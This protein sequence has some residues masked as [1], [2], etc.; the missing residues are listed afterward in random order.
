MSLIA[1]KHAPWSP[2][3]RSAKHSSLLP[4]APAIIQPGHSMTFR[5]LLAELTIAVA[6]AGA[7]PLRAQQAVPGQPQDREPTRQLEPAAQ[8]ASSDSNSLAFREIDLLRREGFSTARQAT[9]LLHLQDRRGQQPTSLKPGDFKLLVNGTERPARIQF[10]GDPSLSAPPLFLLLFPPNQPI[11]HAIGTHQAQLYFAGQPNEL[12]PWKLALFDSDG[13]L[14]PFTNGRSQLLAWLDLSEHKTQPFQYTSDLGIPL[15]LHCRGPWL[16]AA[17]QAI[18]A[19]QPAE[20]AKVIIAFNPIADGLYGENNRVLANDEPQCLVGI[21]QSIGAHI[22]IANSGGPDISIVGGDASTHGAIRGGSPAFYLRQ[23]FAASTYFAYRASTMRQTA[24]ETFGGFSNTLQDLASQI[25]HNLDDNY[26]LTFDLTAHD[27]DKGVPDVEV[28]LAD[29]HQRLAIVNLYP[30]ALAPAPCQKV[31]SKDLMTA[32]WKAAERP[33]SSPS[34]HIAQHVDYFPLREGLQPVL[35]MSALVQW[36]GA[37]PAPTR[38][39]VAEYVQNVT[40]SN[41]ALEREVE[42]GWTGA[43]LSWERDGHLYPG[44]YLWRVVLHDDTGK[45]FASADQKILVGTPPNASLAVSSIVLGTLCR[46]EDPST[47]RKRA[48]LIAAERDNA[49]FL[50][51]PMRAAGCRLKPEPTARFS[52]ADSLHAFLRIYPAGKLAKRPPEDWTASFSLRSSSGIVEF[53]QDLPFTVDSGSG[54]LA[55]L[56][57]PLANPAIQPGPHMLEIDVTGPGLRKPLAVS[58]KLSITEAQISSGN[59]STPTST[60][61]P[62]SPGPQDAPR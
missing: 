35:P 2:P 8:P 37:G 30:V 45:V 11:L 54:F 26:A 24:Q 18:A 50:V 52:P 61:T 12:L 3:T 58:Q 22:Y 10:P 32:M 40:L 9:V 57:L 7:F 29:R 62:R 39:S 13:T 48:E 15:G 16:T 42:A 59:P 56:N 38:L 43:G 53:R 17:E 46:A 47:L 36:T 31:V 25:H 21:A 5:N 28:R 33:V 1:S 4:R 60:G 23:Q 14:T 51:D 44:Q 19:M 27:R 49:Q 41:F 6:L 55:N 20:G 34:F